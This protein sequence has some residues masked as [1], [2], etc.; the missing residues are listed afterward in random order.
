MGCPG[1]V[2]DRTEAPKTA[3]APDFLV[4]ETKRAQLRKAKVLLNVHRDDS[5]YFEWC[6]AL[7]AI[8]NG[9]VVVSEHTSDCRPLIP[10]VHFIS[11]GHA[12][13][14][15]L[16][17]GLAADPE[18]LSELRLAA[19]DFVRGEMPMRDA[20]TRL[21]EIA[22]GLGP[23]RPPVA[24]LRS[25]ANIPAR[26][27]TL[28]GHVR[29][30]SIATAAGVASKAKEL[31]LA[32]AEL[33]HIFRGA[34]ELDYQLGK[35]RAALKRVALDELA[36][37]RALERDARSREGVP[38]DQLIEIAAT[39]SYAAAEPRVSVLVPLHNY[40]V[41][42]VDALESVAASIQESYELIVLDDSSTDGSRAAVEDF[43]ASRPG[44]PGRL[45]AQPYNRGLG[46]ARNALA[47]L[48]RGEFAFFLDADNAIYPSALSRLTEAL[49]ADPGALFAYGMIEVRT[50]GEPTGLVSFRPWEPARLREGNYI[51]AMALFRRRPLIDLGGFDEDIRMTGW[52][53]YDLWCRCASRGLR[54]ILVP[55]I[56]TRYRRTEHSLLALAGID[57]Q[58]AWSM[59]V[60]RYREVLGGA[61]IPWHMRSLHTD[62][63]W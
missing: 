6:R 54:G 50:A 40:A 33:A 2:R 49:D 31:I 24:R 21:L 37:R 48:A 13:L 19:Y 4:E 26:L 55:Q 29:G 8:C 12:S 32:D 47:E 43:L 59:L 20:A 34:S 17:R 10:G 61:P 44:L 9:C 38:V 5:P 53:D 22:T 3:A 25:A 57:H 7:E 27:H 30:A 45:V 42:I 28:R 16:A 56:L 14:G 51:D 15:L 23:G 18:R 41:E 60:A 1:D 35:L 36:V 52:E 11:A 62:A 46:R 39:P 58:V 63:S